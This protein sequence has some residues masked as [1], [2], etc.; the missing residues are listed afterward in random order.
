MA[1]TPSNN[2]QTIC[3]FIDRHD[4]GG[5]RAG[6]QTLYHSIADEL[7]HSVTHGAG[8]EA[9]GSVQVE[10]DDG[11]CPE[12]L[13]GAVGVVGVPFGGRVEGRL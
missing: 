5:V 10:C 7:F 11:T 6:Q 2:L 13:D 4:A 1:G 3:A 9:R 8:A 12:L